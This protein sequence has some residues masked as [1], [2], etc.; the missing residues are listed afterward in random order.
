MPGAGTSSLP[1]QQQQQRQVSAG[2][3]M[4]SAPR[5]LSG[6]SQQQL[7]QQQQASHYHA[8][9][10]QQQQQQQQ[11]QGQ[12]QQ[13]ARQQMPPPHV[14]QGSIGQ[15]MPSSVTPGTVPD[16]LLGGQTKTGVETSSAFTP[17]TTKNRSGSTSKATSRGRAKE[18][19]PSTVPGVAESRLTGSGP[20]L[21]AKVADLVKSLDPTLSIEPDAEEQV[22][23]L[24]DDFVDKV[25]KQSM[26]LA[27]HRSSKT[28]E[29]SDI[30]LILDQQWGI[31]IPG[32]GP[33]QAK[34]KMSTTSKSASAS[35]SKR[36]AD[37][38]SSNSSKAAKTAVGQSAGSGSATAAAA[39][40][41]GTK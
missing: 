14:R 23:Y 7:P 5:R 19:K 36:K 34:K 10:Q 16:P 27:A 21:G 20:L 32:L 8:R 40:A 33:P 6:G 31:K 38:K 39:G 35:G 26:R 1:P 2:T 37:D 9:I 3:G 41:D 18:T 28:L 24:V 4:P 17:T 11:Q 22:L 29:V 25:V 12:P 30:Q 15:G 13:Q